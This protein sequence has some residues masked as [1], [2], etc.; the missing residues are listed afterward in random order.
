MNSKEETEGRKRSRK[1]S[2]KLRWND[3]DDSDEALPKKRKSVNET[4]A[5]VEAYDVKAEDNISHEAAT[6]H[7]QTDEEEDKAS[8]QDDDD[9]SSFL[10]ATP[11]TCGLLQFVFVIS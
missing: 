1:R 8:I 11:E 5:E 9:I 2:I 4:K 7:D 10:R 6:N 3:P